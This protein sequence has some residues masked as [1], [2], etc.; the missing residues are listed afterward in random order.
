MS[1]QCPKCEGD[2]LTLV[3]STEARLVQHDNGE[4][5]T[6]EIGGHEWDDDSS[7]CCQGCG[8]RGTAG[9]FKQ[10]E[11]DEPADIRRLSD[12]W[13]EF[14]HNGKRWSFNESE[15]A[16]WESEEVGFHFVCYHE[17]KDPTAESVKAFIDERGLG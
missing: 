17:I 14:A 8:H 9:E 13:I 2:E 15:L 3:V 1:W 16:L 7:M 5:E 10:E 11:E 12:E 4:F 6:E